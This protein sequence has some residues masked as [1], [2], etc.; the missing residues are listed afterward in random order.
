MKYTVTWKQQT[1]GNADPTAVTEQNLSLSADD[2]SHA[3]QQIEGILET[4]LEIVE[5]V[6][7]TS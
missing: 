5:W 1:I 2:A 3:K 6:S 4:G 7:V